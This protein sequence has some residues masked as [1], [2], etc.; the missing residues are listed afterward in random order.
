MTGYKG[1]RVGTRNPLLSLYGLNMKLK[2][3]K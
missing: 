1:A 2:P 3:I